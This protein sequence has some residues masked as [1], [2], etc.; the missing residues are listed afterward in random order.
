MRSSAVRH[1]IEQTL[2][3]RVPGALT[4]RLRQSPDLLSVGISTLDA[5]LDGGLPR[6]AITELVGAE[7]SGR[8]SFALS[9]VASRLQEGEVG[10]WIDASDTLDPESA[11][12]AGVALD[13][14]LWV[15]CGSVANRHTLI[16]ERH[17]DAGKADQH[18]MDRYGV[19]VDRSLV[20][21]SQAGGG[22][23]PH[24]RSEGRGLS[25]ALQ[26][27]MS[28]PSP[29]A[30]SHAGGNRGLVPPRRRD[31]SIGTPGAPNRS[32]DRPSTREKDGLHEG[33]SDS[34]M[35]WRSA[36]REEQVAT[37]RR[38][39]RR[40]DHLYERLANTGSWKMSN[41]GPRCA[42]PQRR[43]QQP[44][45]H[46]P[47]TYPRRASAMINT[48]DSIA[49]ASRSSSASGTAASLFFRSFS[50]SAQAPS[51]VTARSSLGGIDQALRSVDLLLQSGGFGVI[52]LDL[53]AIAPE[54]VWRIPLATWFRFR[55]AAER[56]RTCFILLTQHPCARSSAELVLQMKPGVPISSGSVM[57]GVAYA[58]RIGRQRFANDPARVSPVVPIRK[59]PQSEHAGRWS[60]QATWM[61]PGA[62]T[63]SRSPHAVESKEQ[64]PSAVLKANTRQSQSSSQTSRKA[65][66]RLRGP[67]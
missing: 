64:D 31:R 40:G 27:L 55:A 9:F 51:Q 65:A 39:A 57:T 33:I 3:R 20:V 62:L 38:P 21:P 1:Q 61:H 54:I 26:S 22:G 66:A 19:S 59:P 6:G 41:A 5:L 48:A 37:D 34:R 30:R 42:E 15:R 8:T 50:E 43:P 46:A 29:P 32:L 17:T 13:R 53:G 2:S 18:T 4:L 49:P 11:A 52:V 10:A 25:E 12:A 35:Q 60:G 16:Q 28:E 56:A 63:A 14:L 47:D 44:A 45:Q 36:D 58:A 24:P 67:R 23:S 7:S